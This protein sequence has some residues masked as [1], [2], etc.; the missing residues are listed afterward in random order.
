MW[1]IWRPHAFATAVAGGPNVFGQGADLRVER[2]EVVSA[3]V[4]RR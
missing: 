2:F 4:R 3:N 1:A